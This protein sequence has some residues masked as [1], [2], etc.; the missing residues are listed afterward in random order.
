[1]QSSILALDIGNTNI[2]VGLWHEDTWHLN[3]RIRTVSQKMPDEYAV[4]LGNFFRDSGLEWTAIKHVVIGSVVPS[5]TS[6][7]VDL[8]QRYAQVDP[9]LVSAR[10]NTGIKVDVDQP[11]QVGADRI[12][13]AAAANKLFGG[14]AIVVDF[15]TATNFDVVSREGNYI[16]GSIAPG[17]GITLDALIGR[18]SPIYKV[19]L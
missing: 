18:T 15:G 10:I 17:I 1:M 9:L 14:P 11:E 13:N 4:L 6:T 7:F 19:A 2:H 8:S 16:G 12:A 3:W 5:L